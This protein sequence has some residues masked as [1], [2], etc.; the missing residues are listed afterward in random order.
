MTRV[1]HFPEKGKHQP[2][3][4]KSTATVT[5]IAKRAGLS[6]STVSA[7]L[8]KRQVERRISEKSVQKVLDAARSLG[9]MPNIAA[10][11]LRDSNGGGRREVVIGILT[12]FEAPVRL[13][14]QALNALQEITDR[15][16]PEG[17]S[18]SVIIEV[19]HAGRLK[20]LPGLIEGRRCNA[21]IITNTVAEDD[22]FL[23]NTKLPFPV[24]LLGRSVPGYPSVSE[25]PARLGLGAAEILVSGGRRKIAVLCP[26]MLTQATQGRVTSFA[27]T[28]L[29]ELGNLPDRIVSSSLS[30]VGG[31]EAMRAYLEQGGQCDGLFTVTDS[32]AVGAYHAIKKSGRKIPEDIAVVGVGDHET[33]RFLDP[34]LTSF[35]NAQN[36][37]NKSAAGILLKMLRGED[38][39]LNVTEVPVMSRLRESTGHRS[40]DE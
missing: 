34:P 9:Y 1:D 24:V 26:Q 2:V 13:V 5:D 20:E 32:L 25:Q 28:S 10:R 16:D 37:M 17:V 40:E 21:A 3:I 30:A 6:P 35:S 19:F 38:V 31:Y 4:Q 14:S 15:T 29:R 33:G 18:Y 27:E 36:A 8:N 11:R 12:S 7:V 23:A 39:E 22:N